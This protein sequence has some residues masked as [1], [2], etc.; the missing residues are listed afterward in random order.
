M[1]NLTS[2]IKKSFLK[3]SKHRY[4]TETE[5]ISEGEGDKMKHRIMLCFCYSPPLVRRFFY[6]TNNLVKGYEL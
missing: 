5:V 4:C 6:Y 3:D 2:E 1:K